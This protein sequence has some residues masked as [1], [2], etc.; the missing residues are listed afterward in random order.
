MS[1]IVVALDLSSDMQPVLSAAE[2][3]CRG[4]GCG[5]VLA[6]V[7]PMVLSAAGVG[8]EELKQEVEQDFA[9]D[10]GLI[11]ELAG[12]VAEKGIQCRAV[13]LEGE[14]SNGILKVAEK[15]NAR[16]IILGSHGHSPLFDALIGSASPAVIH[17]A[18]CPVMLIPLH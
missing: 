5:M 10:V 3:Q 1:V 9:N 11:H 2:E 17:R 4:L 16:M 15:L 6:T 18:N 13:I 14:P 7:E 8:V 12:S